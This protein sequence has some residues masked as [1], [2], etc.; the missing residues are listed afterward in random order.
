MLDIIKES[1]DS[2]CRAII[3]FWDN[4]FLPDDEKNYLRLEVDKLR[5]DN[6]KLLSHII[7]L[8]SPRIE[9]GEASEPKEFKP[10]NL[11]QEPWH[12]KQRKLEAESRYKAARLKNEASDAL[13]QFKSTE[14]LE[15]ELGIG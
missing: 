15:A 13:N 9:T 14:E 6:S 3:R 10:V 7:E 5:L 1:F 12:M 8:T 11:F 2:F 4:R